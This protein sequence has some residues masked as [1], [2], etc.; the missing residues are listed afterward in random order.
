VAS[1]R[2]A[3]GG[4]RWKAE[5]SAFNGR[6]PDDARRNSIWT[7]SI[8]WSGRV[9]FL[10][11]SRWA[12]QV[13]GGRLK[14][15][16][17]DAHSAQRTDVDRI[18]GSATYHRAFVE[19]PNPQISNPHSLGELTLAWGGMRNTARAQSNALLVETSI[20]L[21]DRD[22]LFARVEAVGKTA[23][24]LGLEPDASSRVQ[25]LGGYT[26]YFRPGGALQGGVRVTV[27]A[28]IVPASL[29]TE[30]AGGSSRATAS[31]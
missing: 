6:E 19:F 25:G 1:S 23:H 4:A 27:S 18:T 24:D 8:L 15:A 11:N 22:A 30:Y 16:E 12:L 2:P 10:P 21:K 20:T 29:A 9:W 28:S 7:R 31:S 17:A 14:D 13:S 26:R 5:A 3:V